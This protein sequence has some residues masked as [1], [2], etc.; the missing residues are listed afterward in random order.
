MAP[1]LTDYQE[2]RIIASY[3]E[4]GTYR[5][6]ARA[7]QVS[8]N[9]VRKLVQADTEMLKKVEQKK[10]ENA[11]DVLAYMADKKETVCEIIGS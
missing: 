8:V 5:G 10:A 3:V 4:T 9:T 7:C 11:V 2:K 1:R 6:A